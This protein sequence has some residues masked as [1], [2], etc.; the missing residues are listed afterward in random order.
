M[1]KLKTVKA[2][3]KRIKITKN[4]KL[5][6]RRGGQDHFNTRNTGNQVRRKRRDNKLSDANKKNVKSFI[7]YN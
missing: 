3:S 5:I 2:V 6:V 1:P 7:P 4:D